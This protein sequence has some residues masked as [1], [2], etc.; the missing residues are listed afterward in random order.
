MSNFINEYLKDKTEEI[1]FVELRQDRS[2][3]INSVS[4]TQDTPLPIAVSNM[5]KKVTK[6]IDENFDL[7]Q[8][9]DGMIRIIGIDSDFKY[10]INYINF[11]NAYNS[12]IYKQA[13]N[14]GFEMINKSDLKEALVYFRCAY[15]LAPNEID[16]IY[17]YARCLEDIAIENDDKYDEFIKES[18]EI[19]NKMMNLYPDNYLSYFHLGF[20]YSNNKEYSMAESI[21]KKALKL[22]SPDDVRTEIA[23]LLNDNEA[24]RD[25]EKGSM[26]VLDGF[27]QDGLNLLLSL[28]Y[29]YPDW[30]NLS[31]FIGLAYRQLEMYSDAIEYYENVLKYN[32]AH[33]DTM[34]EIAIC[35]MQEGRYIEAETYLKEALKIDIDNNELLCNLGIVYLQNGNLIEAERYFNRAFEI[36]PDDEIVNEWLTYID[37]LQ[38]KPK[39]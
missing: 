16:S 25:F 12:D 33:V 9:V 19:F 29:D 26:L 38:N 20:Y 13:L 17:N 14:V 8:F 28:S 15:Q 3:D 18:F 7:T 39:N 11:L 22:D 21:W 34:N 37:Q 10:N 31:F 27:Y 5:K 30:W 24:K 35:L 4:L 2:I 32:T 6:A 36:A 1:L 23:K